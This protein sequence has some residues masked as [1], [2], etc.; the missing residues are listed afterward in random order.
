MVSR[1]V[2]C[3]REH[4]PATT[5][6][7][8]HEVTIDDRRNGVWRV[9]PSLRGTASRDTAS[10]GDAPNYNRLRPVYYLKD[11]HSPGSVAG[12]W[13]EANRAVIDRA[14][15]ARQGRLVG[16]LPD[17]IEREARY[18]LELPVGDE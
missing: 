13:I 9:Y 5:D 6:D 14:D 12:T 4:G 11:E 8:P 18:L 10:S 2:E 16:Q 3:L 15:A 7:L 17:A 1:N